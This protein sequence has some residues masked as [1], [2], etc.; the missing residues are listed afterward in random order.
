[1]SGIVS[2]SESN[3]SATATRAPPGHDAG[4][5]L[6][7]AIEVAAFADE[8]GLRFHTAYLGSKVFTGSFDP[9]YLALADADGI[10]LAE[11]IRAF[12]GDPD[13]LEDDRRAGGGLLGYCEVHI[14]QPSLLP[15]Q[16]R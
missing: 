11:A 14:E 16:L 7:Y 13:R 15:F 3:D 6:P 1:M 12:G 5:R 8:E 2:W 4:R 10:T 9:E